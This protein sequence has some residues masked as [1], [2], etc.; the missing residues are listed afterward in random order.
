MFTP[1][2]HVPYVKN[3]GYRQLII[4]D[5]P[6]LPLLALPQ[7]AVAEENSASISS[8]KRSSYNPQ[9]K[10]MEQ[11]LFQRQLEVDGLPGALSRQKSGLSA[12]FLA[13]A[14]GAQ[15]RKPSRTLSPQTD[16]TESKGAGKFS[17]CY[18]LKDFREN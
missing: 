2:V 9:T 7:P 13:W 5:I 4:N 1:V 11:K 12:P 6:E 10:R 14:G 15:S 3:S 17:T 18:A 8:K 16:E